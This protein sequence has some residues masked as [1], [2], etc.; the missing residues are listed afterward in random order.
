MVGNEDP[1]TLLANA[2]KSFQG[3]IVL[4]MGFTFDDTNPDATPIAEMNRLL[5]KDSRNAERVFPYIGGEEINSSPTHAHHRYIINFGEMSEIEARQYED[6]MAIVEQKV[7][8]QRSLVKRDVYRNRWWQ[9]AE[10]QTALYKAIS[11]FDRVLVHAFVSKWM[12]FTF[13]PAN[14]IV[15]GPHYVF[16]LSSYS[17]FASLQARSHETWARF[18]SA[19]FKDDFRYTPSDCFNTFPFP[20]DWETNPT[21]ETTGKAYYEFRADLMVR[22]DEGLTTTYNRFHDPD[23][24]NLDILKLRD[25]HAEC[26]RAVLDAYGWQDIPTTCEFLLD[27]EDEDPEGTSKRKKPWR[28][29][30]PEEVHDEVLARLLK[31]NQERH[32]AE[33]RGHKA[34]GT[35]N[36]EKSQRSNKKPAKSQINATTIP[37]LEI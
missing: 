3:S 31:L 22:H 23:E 34:M 17:C 32:I 27:Y 1:S 21:L 30:W 15:A 18:F 25:L 37:G 24:T 10:K 16:V 2:N 29:R 19:T 11:Q 4:G 7:K 14:V 9:F 6:L 36:Q 35:L 28:Y 5:D 26:D 33:V 12:V 8:P 13:V 20:L